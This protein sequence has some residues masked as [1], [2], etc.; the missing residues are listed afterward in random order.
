MFGDD[1]TSNSGS[2]VTTTT[3]TTSFNTALNGG[4]NEFDFNSVGENKV[5]KNDFG[6]AALDLNGKSSI[7]NLNTY[8][9]DIDVRNTN[10]INSATPRTTSTSDLTDILN[11]FST[12]DTVTN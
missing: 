5:N 11:N 6:G 9:N 2:T 3:S 12:Q 10:Q 1:S 4:K 7:T 8:F